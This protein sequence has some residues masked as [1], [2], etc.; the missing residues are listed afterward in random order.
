M[1]KLTTNLAAFGR[2]LGRQ[3]A[4][5]YFHEKRFKVPPAPRRYPCAVDE[6]HR[7]PI[8]F[9]PFSLAVQVA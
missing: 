7:L 6:N 5:A 3:R 4:I 9:L 2:P 8:T 1:R